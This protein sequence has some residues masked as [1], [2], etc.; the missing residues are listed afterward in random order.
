MNSFK[1]VFKIVEDNRCPLYELDEVFVLTDKSLSF[2][3]NKESC[4][5]LVREMTQLLFEL[6]DQREVANEDDLEIRLYSCSGCSGLIK[7]V[8]VTEAENCLSDDNKAALLDE[9]EEKL[10][11]KISGYPLLQSIPP[12]HLKKLIG[13]CREENLVEGELLMRKGELNKD[14]FII[15]SGGVVIEDGIVTIATLGEGEICGEMSY[16]GNNVAGASVRALAFTSVLRISGLDFG[17]FMK[18]ADSIQLYMAQLLAARLAKANASRGREFDACLRGSIEELAPA[19]LLQV[20]HMH[21]K[22]GTLYLDL[23][24]G[25]GKILFYEGQIVSATYSQDQNE[26]A[27]YAILAENEGT[28]KFTAGLAHKK[29]QTEAIGDFMSLLMEGVRLADERQ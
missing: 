12:N 11:D 29:M 7:F 18:E 2:G 23:P 4:L 22:T 1:A 26:H 19:E 28:Y 13:I 21:H 5:I 17:R 9:D 24:G 8:R 20:F 14:L 16:F 3:E 27:V 6:L 15:L 25:G 10:F